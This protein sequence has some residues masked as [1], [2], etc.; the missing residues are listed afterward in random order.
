LPNVEIFNNYKEFYI[1]CLIVSLCFVK[2]VG[3]IG[4]W[5]P[6]YIIR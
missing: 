6:F 5:V 4:D 3:L 1:M 2:L